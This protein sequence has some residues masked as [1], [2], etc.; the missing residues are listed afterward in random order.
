MSA[1]VITGEAEES[2]SD[3]DFDYDKGDTVNNQYEKVSKQEEA[4]NIFKSIPI[5]EIKSETKLEKIKK[6]FQ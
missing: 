1:E 6:G 4:K 3:E 2:E 5:S